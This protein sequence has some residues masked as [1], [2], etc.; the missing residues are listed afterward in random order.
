MVLA[1]VGGAVVNGLLSGITGYDFKTLI[2]S[3]TF[4]VGACSVIFYCY[5]LSI[6]V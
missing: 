1:L 6:W 4:G 3:V 5:I 2:I